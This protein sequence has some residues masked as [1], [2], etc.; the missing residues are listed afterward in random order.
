MLMKQ[1]NVTQKHS[2]CDTHLCNFIGFL[3]KTASV[4][5][6]LL[7]DTMRTLWHSGGSLHY[8]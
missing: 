6:F 8:G 7:S 2:T 5:G 1:L 4:S 3:T